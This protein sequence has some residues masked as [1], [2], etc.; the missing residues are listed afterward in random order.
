VNRA[1][2]LVFGYLVLALQLA[3]PGELRLGPTAIAPSFVIPFIVFVSLYAP[4]LTAY[5]TALIL[6]LCIDLTTRLGPQGMLV[7]GPHAL[8]M[9]AAAYLIVTL[10]S[11][12][13][14]NT[15][16]LVV[17]SV[18][19]AAM[20]GLVIVAVFTLRSWFT[21][22]ELFT[23]HAAHELTER[24]LSALY[25]AASAAILGL[26]LFPAFKLFRFQD[27]YSRRTTMRPF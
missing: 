20:S 9:L 25:T 21:P 3:L 22:P 18:L 17:F 14:R 10:R 6:G 19:G 11:V 4:A 1:V 15:L 13:N 23:W 7:V 24:T 27:P 2:G 5:W 12:I 26:V 8:G 16:S